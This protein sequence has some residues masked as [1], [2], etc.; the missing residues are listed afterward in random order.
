GG[1]DYW[2][3]G[4]RTGDVDL[5]SIEVPDFGWGLPLVEHAQLVHIQPPPLNSP[6]TEIVLQVD[7]SGGV[8][9][10]APATADQT[11]RDDVA[12]AYQSRLSALTEPQQQEF[13]QKYW[14]VLFDFVTFKSGAYTFDKSKRELHLTMMGDA[15]LD[16]S[17]GYFHVPQSSVGFHPD[18]DRPEGP[19]QDAPFAVDYP[20]WNKTVV[21]LR[22]PPSFVDGRQPGSANVHETLAGIEYDRSA[23][24]NGTTLTVE[25]DARS[26]VPE[27]SYKDAKAAEQR[28]IALND[29]DVSLPL[30]GSYRMTDADFDALHK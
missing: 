21:R 1:K 18:F 9:A 3:D 5:D 25:T 16:W 11:L 13:F 10:P 20:S 26:V 2:L 4:T 30:P 8:Y 29:Q 17:G 22:F 6:E 12:V 23:T 28:L 15:K 27:I 7:A 19:Q 24:I 14:G